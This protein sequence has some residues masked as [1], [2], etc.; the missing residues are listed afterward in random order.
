MLNDGEMRGNEPASQQVAS[1]HV[2]DPHDV[3]EAAAIRTLFAVWHVYV[4][5]MGAAAMESYL[6][7]APMQFWEEKTSITGFFSFCEVNVLVL[8]TDPLQRHGNMR[9]T[10]TNCETYRYHRGLPQTW[11]HHT[12]KYLPKNCIPICGSVRSITLGERHSQA[13]REFSPYSH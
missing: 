13:L 8:I 3:V 12:L 11:Q 2:S 9:Q 4:L 5:H 1:E 6:E 7:T 10:I